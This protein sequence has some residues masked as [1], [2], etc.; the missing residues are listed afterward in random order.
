M[1][2][3][4]DKFQELEENKDINS[5]IELL[6]ANK[7]QHRYK[8]LV[9]L[10]NIRDSAAIEDVRK[11]LDDKNATVRETAATYFIMNNAF[12]KTRPE[13][14]KLYPYHIRNSYIRIKRII[15]NSDDSIHS[16]SAAREDINNKLK[17]EAANL[18]ANAIIDVKYNNMIFKFFKGIKYQGTAI[19]IDNAEEV[20]PRVDNSWFMGGY[21]IGIGLLYF[22]DSSIILIPYGLFMIFS[23]IFIRR[24]YKNK[25]YFL[26]FL[27]ALTASALIWINFIFKNGYQYFN[28]Y[29][30]FI[31]AFFI[32][33]IILFI[34]EYRKRKTD[35]KMIWK[36]KWGF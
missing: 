23:E 11:L 24:G 35:P 25:T 19:I 29:F 22:N 30:Y 10:I 14:I 18:G 28:F 7:W 9:S 27:V 2:I 26:V 13:D 12:P 6:N 3:F 4:K 34:Y 31:T 33:L 1:A 8:A 36:N 21:F 16:E 5:L 20:R 15:A 17:E 32:S